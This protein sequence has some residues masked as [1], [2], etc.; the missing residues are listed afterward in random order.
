MALNHYVILQ[1]EL[2][3]CDIHYTPVFRDIVVGMECRSREEAEEIKVMAKQLVENSERLESYGQHTRGLWQQVFKRAIGSAQPE[4][5][6]L[7]DA[8][9]GRQPKLCKST[10]I[11][12]GKFFWD[13][14]PAFL[15]PVIP[16]ED[17]PII[18]DVLRAKL[19]K[20]ERVEA[21][22]PMPHQGTMSRLQGTLETLT[23]PATHTVKAEIMVPGQGEFT[24]HFDSRWLTD[25][26]L[27][28]LE[29][30]WELVIV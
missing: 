15:K 28:K 3:D 30:H 26:K 19:S 5:V 22:F 20:G 8:Y 7:K 13:V 10:F 11:L 1:V 16:E 24:R 14:V 23:Y 6:K 17:L 18:Y 4:M 25:W 12:E 29:S 2:E 27:A 9:L 21:R